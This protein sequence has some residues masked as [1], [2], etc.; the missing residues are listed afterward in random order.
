MSR[1]ASTLVLGAALAAGALLS[2]CKKPPP[3]PP[4]GACCSPEG[5]CIETT[6]AACSSSW[7]AGTCT[8]NPCPPPPPKD[9]KLADIAADQK[10]DPRVQF[11]DSVVVTEESLDLGKAIV[12]FADT[13]ARGDAK[14]LRPQLTRPAQAVLADLESTGG[15]EDATKGIEAVRVVFLGPVDIASAAVGT[16]THGGIKEALQGLQSQAMAATKDI[17]KGLTPEQTKALGE[18][19]AQLQ[20]DAMAHADQIASNPGA[21]DEYMA[22]FSQAATSAGLSEEQIDK[23]KGAFQAVTGKLAGAAAGGESSGGSS[24]GGLGMLLAVQDPQGAYL[25]GWTVQKVGDTWLFGNAPSTPDVRAR[26]SAWD[27]TGAEGFQAMK[28][29]SAPP[30]P[31]PVD[32][33]SGGTGTGTGGG[34][35]DSGGGG[36]GGSPPSTPPSGPEGAP[37]AAPRPPA[38]PPGS[39]RGPGGH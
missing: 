4:T 7:Q 21:L 34:G 11:A 2:G 27:G 13:L 9:V 28:L 5:T 35:G 22:T 31:V 1:N 8:P 32:D 18:A 38:A 17:F 14:G 25:L 33:A 3:P 10:P 6:Q 15:W 16:D 24:G 26:A 29:A 30:P 20:R 23:L 12:K 19:M 39:P 37:P 36:G